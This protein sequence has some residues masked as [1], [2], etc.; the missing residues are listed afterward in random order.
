MIEKSLH[1]DKEFITEAGAVLPCLDITYH[2]SAEERGEKPV[3]W[4][5][6][7]LTANSDP[8][9]WWPQMVGSGCPIDTDKYY[10]VCVNMLGSPY[11]STSPLSIDPSTS[12]SYLIKFPQITVRDIIAATI[13][14]RKHLGINTI[15][16]LVGSSIGGFQAIE[17]AV[18]EP[19]VFKK[20]VFIATGA[21][22]NAWLSATVEAQRMA[23]RADQ[24]F[25][26]SKDKDGGKEGLKCARAIALLTYR[27]YDGYVLT[28]SEKDEDTL[29]AGRAASYERYQGEKLAKRFD[30]YCYQSVCDSLDSHNVGRHR[31]GVASA[32]GRITAET[33]VISITTDGIFPPCEMSEWAKLIPGAQ[34]FEIESRFGHDGFLLETEQLA[35]IIFDQDGRI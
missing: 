28:Q 10:V 17:W 31:G 1:I 3:V 21:R 9:D 26:A 22:I 5:C 20:A 8:T 27:S 16:L 15:D 19:D 7:A 2:V 34:Y 11:G 4:I 18:Q 24:T 13:M 25:L 29:F 33:K 35:S 30:A 14:I 6:H 12:K 23:L 32:L